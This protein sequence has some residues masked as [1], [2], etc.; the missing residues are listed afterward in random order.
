MITY[1][2]T[3]V[4]GIITSHGYTTKALSDGMI[5]VTNLEYNSLNLGDSHN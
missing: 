5:E 1:Y 3:V 4:A 2:I